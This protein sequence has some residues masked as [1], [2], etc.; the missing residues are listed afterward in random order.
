MNL[1]DA[2]F[3]NIH[4]TNHVKND[5]VLENSKIRERL[6]DKDGA[7]Y[8]DKRQQNYRLVKA[9]TV[10]VFDTVD[11]GILAITAFINSQTAGRHDR[12]SRFELIEE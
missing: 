2:D 4:L 5:K 1:E 9:K 6:K 12:K 11:N 8:Y 10:V 3:D 7:I